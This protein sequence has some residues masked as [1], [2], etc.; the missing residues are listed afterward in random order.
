[1][2]FQVHSVL[3]FITLKAALAM[4]EYTSY[5][6]VKNRDQHY[7]YFVLQNMRMKCKL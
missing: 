4:E 2:Q 1:M 6:A 7:P 5:A 3:Q